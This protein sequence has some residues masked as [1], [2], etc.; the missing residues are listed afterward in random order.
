MQI[1]YLAHKKVTLTV[2]DRVKLSA[3]YKDWSCCPPDTDLG[4]RLQAKAGFRG[5]RG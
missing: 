1:A 4:R 5:R 3:D 2:K